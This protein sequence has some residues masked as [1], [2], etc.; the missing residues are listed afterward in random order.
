M[1][2]EQHAIVCIRT[3][4]SQNAMYRPTKTPMRLP[5]REVG[6]IVVINPTLKTTDSTARRTPNSTSYSGLPI[7]TATPVATPVLKLA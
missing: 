2:F 6:P 7:S 4:C 3:G 5:G 1:S